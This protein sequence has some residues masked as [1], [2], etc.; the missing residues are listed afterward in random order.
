MRKITIA[1][2]ATLILGSTQAGYTLKVPLEQAQGGNLPHNS[3]F[4]GQ[5]PQ[6]QPQSKVCIYH[7]LNE[8]NASVWFQPGGGGGTRTSRILWLGEIIYNVSVPQSYDM[9][10]YD[11]GGYR[12]TRGLHIAEQHFEV[13]RESI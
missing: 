7:Q 13:C 8:D 9:T 4:F 3:I 5:L 11:H 1:T 12:Y 10:S 2:L 6:E